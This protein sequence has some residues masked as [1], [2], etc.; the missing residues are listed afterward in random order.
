MNDMNANSEGMSH[1]EDSSA[2]KP[3]V[4]GG[5]GHE[6]RPTTGPGA[7]SSARATPRNGTQAANKF[8]GRVAQL[9]VQDVVESIGKWHEMM[10][11][12]S[13]AWFAAESA[14]GEAIVAAGLEARQEQLLVHVA[15]CFAKQVW[16]PIRRAE[17]RVGNT[18][19]SGQ[20]LA[21][22]AMLALLV[23]DRL[24]PETFELA[25]R[26]FA[27]LIPAAELEPE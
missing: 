23:R 11:A 2:D 27:A 1:N 5:P 12:E 15:E 13:G 17:T 7:E 14:I 8:I 16:R 21:T 26:P 10:R 25:Y 19:A 3:A 18:E 6:P 22:V 24:S 4:P 20:Y 9:D